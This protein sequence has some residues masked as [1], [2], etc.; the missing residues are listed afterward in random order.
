MPPKLDLTGV[1]RQIGEAGRQFAR[2]ASEVRAVR[3]KAEQVAR[4]LD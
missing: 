3:E 4:A 2:L 1:G